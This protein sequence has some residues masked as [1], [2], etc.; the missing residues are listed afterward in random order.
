MS[1]IED[2]N[3]VQP[4]F[5]P[6]YYAAEY[7]DLQFAID[8]LCEHFC[9]VGWYEGRNP[10]AYF[11]VVSYLQHYPDVASVSIN[12][13]A[14]YL[15][16]RNFEA[17][18]AD[19]SVSPSARTKLA[20]GYT[21]TNWVERLRPIVDVN[22]YIGQL[23]AL[24]VVGFDPTA[25]FAYRGWREGLSPNPDLDL[26]KVSKR[27]GYAAR[28]LINP[29]LAE[30]E[31]NEGRYRPVPN[32]ETPV[33]E[34]EV[35]VTAAAAPLPFNVKNTDDVELIRP[36]FDAE[37]YLRTYPEL[38]L[39]ESTA[40]Y[41]YFAVGW[42]EGKNPSPS[43]S[44][45]WY[46]ESHRDVNAAGVNPLWH[47][48]VA[49]AAEG[50][51]PQPPDNVAE[52]D[53]D[54]DARRIA[55]IR[56][57]FS[58]PH[59]LAQRKD[60]VD[61]G[62]D[63][64]LHYYYTGWREGSNP[65]KEFD[66][67]YYLEGNEDVRRA[68]INPFWHYL[69]EG[70]AEARPCLRPGG[71]RRAILE[72]AQEPRRRTDGYVF[73]PE[74]PMTHRTFLRRLVRTLD[75]TLTGV[76]ISISHDCYLRVVGGMQIFISDEQKRFQECG[77]VYIHV[78]P[79]V[80]K[81]TLC[82]NEEGS[83]LVRV[84]AGGGVIGV[85]EFKDL[86]RSLQSVVKAVPSRTLVVHSMFGFGDVHVCDLYDALLP[87]RRVYWLHDYS[88]LCEGYNLLRNDLQFC[89][90]PDKASM[91]CRIC[92]YGRERS[93]YLNRVQRVFAHCGFEVVAPSSHTLEFWLSHG[94]LQYQRAVVHPHWKLEATADRSFL[95]RSS[96]EPTRVAFVG[97][98][99]SSKGWQ[100]YIALTD[101]LDGD[102]RYCFY[103]FA[104]AGVATTP[105]ATFVE[106]EVRPDDRNAMVNLLA[107]HEIDFVVIASPWPE[108]FSYV[109]YEALAAGCR[110]LCFEDSGNVAALAKSSGRGLVFANTE[111]LFLFFQSGSA[112]EQASSG[113]KTT[114]RIVNCGTTATL[115]A[116][117][118]ED[119]PV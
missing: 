40:I 50:R 82:D 54:E 92:I 33:S 105:L 116:A 75:C 86:I 59:Y 115:S 63:P 8:E 119:A 23:P 24:P 36:A 78:C 18:V 11:D 79:F 64:V 9:T 95:P 25:H 68:G 113:R 41:H 106:A 94:D 14:H 45:S 26:V 30:I 66:T 10:N 47:Y 52:T 71:Y 35:P 4:H 3:I 91:S 31:E 114:Y 58:V 16:R 29:V 103:H 102:G 12:P 46:L 67:A 107:K 100:I 111:E 57:S 48:V 99:S 87:T 110:I 88:S 32:L 108:T 70:R 15:T 80:P 74:V 76:V 42:K 73:Q 62:I 84:A 65:N 28:L 97:F 98:P 37:F 7:P 17:R 85:V 39:T 96:N 49:G 60:V 72:N 1:I 109:A 89:H 90:A 112:V 38:G 83:F 5:D 93:T 13:F 22:F 101:L 44:S 51:S 27:Q 6:T 53:P 104:A 43:F 21:L 118:V 61:S 69:V 77:Y 117:R 81:L 55:L 34:T 2:I 19:S 20:F 56:G